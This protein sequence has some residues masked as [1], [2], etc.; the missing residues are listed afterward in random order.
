M[1]KSEEDDHRDQ[2]ERKML[3]STTS[4]E[5]YKDNN[6]HW[7][8]FDKMTQFQPVSSTAVC[9]SCR[10]CSSGGGPIV[11]WIIVSGIMICVRFELLNVGTKNTWRWCK[12]NRSDWL[13]ADTS[14]A[15]HYLNPNRRYPFHNNKQES[16]SR[17][18]NSRVRQHL[19]NDNV[20]KVDQYSKHWGILH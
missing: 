19:E 6:P 18:K 7:E 10:D 17:S 15:D 8:E 4:D 16:W 12:P 1:A 11:F 14:R 20:L 13:W 3:N 9:C 5:S 2:E